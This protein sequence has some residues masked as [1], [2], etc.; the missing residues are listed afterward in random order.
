MVENTSNQWHI[1][2]Y[3]WVAWVETAIKFVALGVALFTF[4]NRAPSAVL[5]LPDGL[6]L[7]QLVILVLLSLGL[8]AAIYDRIIEREIIAMGFVIINS[9]GHWGMVAA[10][11]ITP[12]PETPL[13]IFA[14]LMLL[15]D[16][17][18]LY[19]LARTK[20]RVR[21]VPLSVMYGLTLFFVAGYALI[22]V[23][24]LAG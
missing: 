20:F 4:I 21:D 14:G 15:G 6:A 23:L 19:W 16:L 3:S 2:Q 5:E 13:L 10:L 17:I 7:I 24:E 12:R 22:V 1:T 18:K 11:L 9:L 8:L